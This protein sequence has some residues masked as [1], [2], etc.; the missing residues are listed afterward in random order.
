MTGA[1]RP[2]IEARGITRIYP[3]GT[4]AYDGVSLTVRP[5]EVHAVV[6]ENG[7][8]KSTLMKN[9]FGLER[10]RAGVATI[11]EDRLAQGLAVDS[12]IAE[13]LCAT[14]HAPRATRHAPR[15]TTIRAS[16]GAAFSIS[17]RFANTHGP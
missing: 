9:L 14:R 4:V 13:N 11:P 15:A 1:N 3:G 6:G 8:G 12:S 10:R 16:C 2:V 17:L 5:G 7:A